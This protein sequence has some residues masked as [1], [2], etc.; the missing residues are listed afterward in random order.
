MRENVG[1]IDSFPIIGGRSRPPTNATQKISTQYLNNCFGRQ[2][3]IEQYDPRVYS[4]S[5]VVQDSKSSM[6]V[7]HVVS[8]DER[9]HLTMGRN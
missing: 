2:W 1:K 9:P 6:G 7:G 4:D 8:C 3:R 5:Q